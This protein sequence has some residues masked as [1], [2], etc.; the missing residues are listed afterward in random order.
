MK[1]SFNSLE[2]QM[3]CVTKKCYSEPEMVEAI[4]RVISPRL[5]LRSDLEGKE[6]LK[7]TSLRQVL[8]AHYAETDTTVLYQQQ[9]K[10]MQGA[11]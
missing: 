1:L 11:N 7:L 9:T 2:H 10:A 6:D 3:D 8:G 5:K 4:V